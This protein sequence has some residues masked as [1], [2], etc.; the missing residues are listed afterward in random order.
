[1]NWKTP[2]PDRATVSCWQAWRR[3]G[4]LPGPLESEEQFLRRAERSSLEKT[5]VVDLPLYNLCVD[6]L[7]VAFRSSELRPWEGAATLIESD[8]EGVF[9]AR[10]L[11]GRSLFLSEKTLLQH[12]AVHA[13]RCAFKDSLVEEELAWKTAPRSWLSNAHLLA[14]DPLQLALIGGALLGLSLWP[15]LQE[16]WLLCWALLLI[17]GASLRVLRT[18]SIV[19]R[20][21]LQLE[22]AG[23]DPWPLLL[24]LSKQ[25]MALLG[26]APQH[27]WSSFSRES[28]FRFCFLCV[29]LDL[30]PE[31][32]L[33]AI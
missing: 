25:E 6:W 30:A 8:H 22:S 33:K 14:F 23:I 31:D 4:L 19:R 15:A 24:H 28:P 16:T 29:T 20:A 12:E 5:L 17:L 13:V 9:S 11:L 18:R 7:P 21:C 27:F 26:S 3:R 10:I 1:M 2:W 32:L